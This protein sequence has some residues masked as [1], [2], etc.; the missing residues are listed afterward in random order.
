[1]T[2]SKPGAPRSS[3][4]LPRWE[5]NDPAFWEQEGKARAWR[6]L[7]VTTDGL[8]PFAVKSD[9]QAAP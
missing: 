1:M 7:W 3:T 2:T 6:T 9:E 4:W 8:R 5:P